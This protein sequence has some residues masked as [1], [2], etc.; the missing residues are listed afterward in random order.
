MWQCRF[1]S[2]L[3]LLLLVC[4]SIASGQAPATA[5]ELLASFTINRAVNE[6]NLTFSVR[7]SRGHLRTDLTQADFELL[8]DHRPPERVRYFQRQTELPLRVAL[9]IDSSTSINERIDFEKKAAS[10]FLRRILRKGIDE[11]L[12][13][14]FDDQVRLLHDFTTDP[15]ALQSGIRPIHPQGDTAL[16]DAITFACEK[17]AHVPDRKIFRRVIILISDGED[18][19]SRKLLSDAQQSAIANDAVIFSLNTNDVAWG[20]TKG[21]AV[22]D[23]LSRASG[24]NILPAREQ[25]EL[26]RAFSEVEKT[27]RTQYAVGYTPADFR[28]DGSFRSVQ[29]LSRKPHFSVQCRRG[30]YAA[31]K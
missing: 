6:V 30:Y 15:E 19:H 10:V 9:L 17:L 22:L 18:T 27:L 2:P 29:I 25:T 16:Y 28:P 20:Y 26:R 13:I 1:C 14:S 24:G 4:D 23:L 11:A 8:D 12:V 31:K 3:V 5:S 7:D 21:E